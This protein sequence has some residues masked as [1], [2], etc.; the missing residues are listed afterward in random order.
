MKL[1]FTLAALLASCCSVTW[2]SAQ[3]SDQPKEI[4]PDRL[5]ILRA[6]EALKTRQPRLPLAPPDGSEG[7]GGR[8]GVVNNGRMRG[9]YLPE[10]LRPSGGRKDDPNM[11]IPYDF[12]VELFWL[13]SRANN[14]HYC[15]GHQEVKL[16]KVGVDQ[17]CRL[18]L[19]I[20]WGKFDQ[21]HQLAFAFTKKLTLEPYAIAESDI[22]ELRNRFSD[23]EILEI[24]T[25]VG[26]YNSTNRWTDSLGIPQED[27]RDFVSTLK[28]DGTPK[29]SV[30]VREEFSA[31]ALPTDVQQWK[32]KLLK[33]S[34]SDSVWLK[35]LPVNV[36]GKR[37]HEKL[38]LQFPV[39]GQQFLDNLEAAENHGG[40]TSEQKDWI[41]L[42]CSF[43]DQAYYVQAD[44][45][46]RLAKAGI[47]QERAFQT[48]HGKASDKA[49]Q[50]AVTFCRK[51]TS[52]PQ[53]MTD[54]DIAELQEVFSNEQVAEIVYRVG[55]AA[56]LDRLVLASGVGVA[57]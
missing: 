47:D 23:L 19:D 17:Q 54:Q 20:D 18:D 57:P 5:A 16:E 56:Q 49:T 28:L 37:P 21:R 2:C 48:L 52:E 6:L 14:C 39:T 34:E 11:S 35:Q 15:L 29:S 45:L 12:S 50:L 1:L 22:E 26:R 30:A 3:V 13:V 33:S 44:A 31:R 36:E 10:T 4:P 43:E 41:W 24:V 8:L 25:I 51:L 7:A 55:L 42:A 53:R 9:Q 40:L 32:A 38:L 46:N 27:H